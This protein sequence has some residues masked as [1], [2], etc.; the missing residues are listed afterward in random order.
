MQ[1]SNLKLRTL[2]RKGIADS[3]YICRQEYIKIL[4]DPGVRVFFV[5]ATLAYPIL[6]GYV[7]KNEALRDLPIAVVDQS[8]TSTSREYI[9]NI[10]ATP[11][12][13]VS[14]QCRDL[15]E[16]KD[17]YLSREVYGILVV[18]ED[19]SQKINTGQQGVVSVYADMSSFMNY[20]A[21]MAATSYV[22]KEMCVDIQTRRLE[23]Q[24]LN[25]EQASIAA[26]PF[27]VGEQP[28]F[29]TGGGYASFLL[30][31]ILILIIQQTLLMGI[32]MLAGTAREQNKWAELIPLSDRYHGTFRIVFGKGLCYFSWYL[33]VSFFILYLVPRFFNLPHFVNAGTLVLFLIPFLCA[34]IFFAMSLSVF[35]RNR[36]NP[37]L[38]FLF[39]SVPLLMLSGVSWP[40]ESLPWPWR[41]IAWFF[42]S[43]HGIQGFLRLNTFQG[44]LKDV[45]KEYFF[46]WIQ[47][48]I[49]FLSACLLYR[50]L[51]IKCKPHPRKK[52][53]TG[54]PDQ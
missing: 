17:L 30:P 14:F 18:S 5:L 2:I 52:T 40:A 3:L 1:K 16:A 36:E 9:R 31:A 21:L 29:N 35:M 12:V 38:I 23:D 41:I 43:T 11:D 33:F 19:F 45:S 15:T 7:Y 53:E 26:S 44:D 28:L 8:F 13:K 49:Y 4:G 39:L 51:L 54:T 6:Y 10:D 24:G 32:G 42:P 34:A 22:M 20:K 47:T 48:G 50:S 37:I 46:L 25:R 27:Q